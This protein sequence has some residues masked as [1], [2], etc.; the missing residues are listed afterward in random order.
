MR[1]YLGASKGKKGF[2]R[3]FGFVNRKDAN[4]GEGMLLKN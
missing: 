4:L 2:Y 1:V 3:Q